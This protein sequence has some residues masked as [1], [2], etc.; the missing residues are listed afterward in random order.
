MEPNKLANLLKGLVEG[1]T[2][3]SK[4]LKAISESTP[5]EIS[6]AEQK[7]LSKGYN[8]EDMK[9]F[10]RIHLR[11]V[12]EDSQKIMDGLEDGHPIKTL[13][14][15]HE[16]ILGFLDELD[17]LVEGLG[18]EVTEKE[19]VRLMEIA[20][21]LVETEKHHEREEE[22]LFPRLEGKGIVGPPRVMRS[23]HEEMLPKKKRLKELAENPEEN[24]KEIKDIA[25]FLS[26]HLRDHIFKE[27]NI[28]YP[29]A[30]EEII[31]WDDVKKQSD[32]IGYCCFTPE[33]DRDA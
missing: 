18:I 32:D 13:M 12:R 31:D 2:S 23:E 19:R 30:L 9:D 4:A 15:E 6:L 1:T 26:F 33:V 7:L 17:E 21:H 22:A 3:E 11:A 14:K 10:C 28:L 27:N 25:G 29:T 5:E 20:E 8:L 16:M 24:L